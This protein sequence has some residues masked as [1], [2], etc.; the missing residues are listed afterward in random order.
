MAKFDQYHESRFFM[1]L[2]NFDNIAATY[3]DYYKSDFGKKVDL[4]EKNIVRHMLSGLP[5]ERALE[6]GCGTGHWTKFFRHLGFDVIGIDISEKMLEQAR[7]RLP[8]VMCLKADATRLPF[9]DQTFR[10]VFAIT[11][12]EFIEDQQRAFDEAYRVLKTG[13]Y[14]LIG[15]LNQNSELGQTKDRSETF[16]NAKF[17]TPETL[18]G[19]LEK[20]GSPQIRGGVVLE[21][22]KILDYYKTLPEN[23]KLE[24]GAFLVGL[25]RKSLK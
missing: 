11:V 4:I 3:D 20:F 7:K 16:K 8:Q 10:Y 17:F 5:R 22:G 19:Y 12:F 14:F 23:T 13:G 15:A 2:F 25:V 6:I 9:A 24:K 18:R 21:N 1:S